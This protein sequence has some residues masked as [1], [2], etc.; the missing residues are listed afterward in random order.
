MRKSLL[1]AALLCLMSWS[2]IA[3]DGPM[4]NG[5]PDT[6]EVVKG[7][8]LWDISNSFLNSPWLWP[9]IWH[10]NPQIENPHLIY[11]GDVISLVYIDGK[12]RLTVTSRGEAS[13]TIKLGP[14]VRSTPIDSVIPAIPLDKI[15]SLLKRSRVVASAEV[16]TGAPYIVTAAQERVVSGVDDTIYARGNFDSNAPAYGIYRQGD[17]II[18]PKTKE[19][20][21]V[22]A[23]DLGAADV[24]QIRGEI[25]TLLVTRSESEIRAGDRLL[26][27]EERRIDSTFYP[28]A[29]EAAIDGE[30]VGVAGGISQ[31]GQFDNVLVNRGD[32]EGLKPGNILAIN[33]KL[34]VIDEKRKEQVTM[35]AHR[36]GLLMIF[37]TFE[38]VSFGIVLETTEPLLVGDQLENP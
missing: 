15:N 9:E 23:V 17:I 10:A 6:Y 14:K 31:I 36:V 20:L 34:T 7:D 8:T 16:L 21:G 18:D 4:K 38:K 32:R 33:R 25:A 19:A 35:P 27:S 29:P 5:H 24:K 13:R 3:A 11:P 30:I 37:K 26:E 1:G 12:P 2:A 28:S 22:M